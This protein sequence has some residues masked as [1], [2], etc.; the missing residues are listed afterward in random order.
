[1]KKSLVSV[2]LGIALLT[3]SGVASAAPRRSAEPH[4]GIRPERTSAP[5]SLDLARWL[6]R[7]LLESA[8]LIAPVP[9]VLPED[10][11]PTG[12]TEPATVGPDSVCVPERGHCPVG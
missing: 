8:S 3:A 10:P 6:A 11:Q 5:S 12:E 4:W 7:R 2:A 1:M 9:V